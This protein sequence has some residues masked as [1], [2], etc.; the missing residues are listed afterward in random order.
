MRGHTQLFRQVVHVSGVE[1]E[2]FPIDAAL[3]AHGAVEPEGLVRVKLVFLKI[4]ENVLHSCVH[5]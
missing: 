3:A 2:V 5:F 1:Q 4:I